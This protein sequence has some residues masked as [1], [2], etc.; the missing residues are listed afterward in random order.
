MNKQHKLDKILGDIF[1]ERLL[2]NLADNGRIVSL[3]E[4]MQIISRGD[5]IKDIPIVL[6]GTAKVVRTDEKGEEHI[7]FYLNEKEACTATF[8][9]CATSKKSEIDFIM[10]T[11]GELLLYPVHLMD[12]L[13]K[14]FPSWRYYV[15]KNFNKRMKEF[16]NT[17][18]SIVFMKMDQR[19]L[20][21]LDK[22]SKALQTKV[23]NITHQEIAN[24]LS[25]SRVV[26]SRLLKQLEHEGRIKLYRNRINILF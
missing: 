18:D 14:E 9:I 21:Y 11:D 25:T 8:S 15:C 26:V 1:S 6:K 7:L 2:K 12:N 22:A 17:M 3:E 23:L 4:G 10:E 24:D 13:T 5:D 16:L 19:I 20:K